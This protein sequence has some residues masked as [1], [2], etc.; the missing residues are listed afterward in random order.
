M[1]GRLRLIGFTRFTYKFAFVHIRDSN[2][3]YSRRSAGEA[4]RHKLGEHFVV[5]SRLDMRITW[6]GRDTTPF[7]CALAQNAEFT[8]WF[9][10]PI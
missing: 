1:E 6:T 3:I 5:T 2:R 9:G 4:I 7:V 8:A 10:R